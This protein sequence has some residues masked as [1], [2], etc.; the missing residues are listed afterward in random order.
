MKR[1]IIDWKLILNWRTYA[2]VKYIRRPLPFGILLILNGHNN[3]LPLSLAHR[4]HHHLCTSHPDVSLPQRDCQ[5]A[6]TSSGVD[7]QVSVPS[8]PRLVDIY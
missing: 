8:P 7:A 3:A 5:L 1:P 2:K 4:P 6:Q